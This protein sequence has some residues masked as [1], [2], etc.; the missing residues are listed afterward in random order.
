MPEQSPIE[1]V[2]RALGGFIGLGALGAGSYFIFRA[3]E[4]T[5]TADVS[6]VDAAPEVP[7]AANVTSHPFLAEF[8]EA[9]T[10]AGV[11]LQ[12]ADDPS[13]VA[14]V[15]HESNFK[16]D[17]K[18]PNSTAYGLFQFIQSTWKHFLTEVPYPT[19][20]PYW[21]AVGGFRYI[22]KRYGDPSRAWAFWQATVQVSKGKWTR[23][24]ALDSLPTD[25]HAIAQ[26][27]FDKNW[28][29]Y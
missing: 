17:A 9:T 2:F 28:A 13:L 23:E 4:N 18:N 8:Q 26:S 27:W 24:V 19:P 20:D 1:T 5:F 14:L 15:R 3:W 25:L 11:P 29:G 16:P 10:T 22:K 7:M 6:A 12:W 21:Q